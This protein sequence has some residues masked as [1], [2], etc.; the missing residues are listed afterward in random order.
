[1]LTEAYPT[2]QDCLPN[3]MTKLGSLPIPFLLTTG[4]QTKTSSDIDGAGPQQRTYC[5][6]CR[7]PDTFAF[8][9]EP[10]LGPAVPC[11]SSAEC[12]RAPF[13]V[14][15]QREDGAFGNTA[16]T[17]ITETGSSGGNL[18]DRQPH[19]ATLV[20]VFCI[21]PTF[22]GLVDPA[23]GLPGPGAVS[24]PGQAQLVP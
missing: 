17:T 7:D 8:E 9:G 23:A 1:M 15:Q 10:T 14:C 12:T 13:T 18:T 21:P 5:A 16:A 19:N 6:F 4:T 24:L 20:S 2:S 3:E 22:S 11:T